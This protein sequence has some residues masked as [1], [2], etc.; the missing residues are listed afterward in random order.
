MSIRKR[1]FECTIDEALNDFCYDP[2]PTSRGKRRRKQVYEPIPLDPSL[3]QNNIAGHS[4]IQTPSNTQIQSGQHADDVL[5]DDVG[6]LPVKNKVSILLQSVMKPNIRN[7]PFTV[8]LNRL[9][10]I[11]LRN[12]RTSV[13]SSSASLPVAK[14]LHNPVSA[15]FV[16]RRHHPVP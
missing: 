13:L 14:H 2:E 6:P 10:T 16:C 1:D 5:E 11:T 4:G 7:F 8:H 9:R 12:T 3:S 15:A